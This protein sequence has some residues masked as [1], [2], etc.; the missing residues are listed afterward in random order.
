ML[1]Y[2][3]LHTRKLS[4]ELRATSVEGGTKDDSCVVLVFVKPKKLQT[5]SRTD[6]NE[7]IQ[8]SAMTDGNV[9]DRSRWRERG[10]D[11]EEREE[12]GSFDHFSDIDVRSI[13]SIRVIT[14]NTLNLSLSL[15]LFSL[16]LS[17]LRPSSQPFCSC[18]C[19]SE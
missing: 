9:M 13:T 14:A 19:G 5:F 15:P 6:E 1:F 3:F 12:I 4:Y 11:Q 8:M 18:S 17:L 10:G 16:S 7:V 2:L